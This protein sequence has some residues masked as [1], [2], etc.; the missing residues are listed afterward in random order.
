[1]SEEDCQGGSRRS[2]RAAALRTRQKLS[3]IYNPSYHSRT[4]LR[5]LSN[6]AQKRQRKMDSEINQQT[7][8]KTTQNQQGK[9]HQEK[10]TNQEDF[11]QPDL[12]SE[13][14]AENI[15][16]YKSIEKN[17]KENQNIEVQQLEKN[18][19]SK[20]RS[21]KEDKFDLKQLICQNPMKQIGY[22]FLTS[23]IKPKTDNL[24]SRNDQQ[25]RQFTEK[26]ASVFSNLEEYQQILQES[27]F[28]DQFFGGIVLGADEAGRGPLAGPVVAASCYVPLHVEIEGI[29][30]SKK[31]MNESK[32]KQICD[33]IINHP[34]I[35]FAISVIEPAEIDQINILQASL[36]AMKNATE[37][38][39]EKIKQNKNFDLNQNKSNYKQEGQN[40][41]YENQ[42]E[43]KNQISTQKNSNFQQLENQKAD[44]IQASNL[45]VISNQSSQNDKIQNNNQNINNFYLL[46]D[47][48]F[49]PKQIKGI[50]QEN[51]KTVIKGDSKCY[52]IAAASIIAKVHRDNLMVDVYDKK[53]PMYGFKEH[54][55]YPTQKH[56]VCC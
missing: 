2:M 49:A 39:V 37:E 27:D 4:P 5:T 36:K 28:I 34:E 22:D 32:R 53:F 35:Q 24:N 48:T 25:I 41:D 9:T 11:L 50:N 47:G 15:D 44:Q 55:G 19:C 26:Y 16:P 46:V 31:I 52:C 23:K 10:Q 54:K 17:Q 30:D 33:L 43:N 18:R 56:D 12:I 1:M 21:V 51:V 14:R 45:D 38:L 7:C 29:Q 13:Q 40:D 3:Q 8:K 6:K 42:K 20:L